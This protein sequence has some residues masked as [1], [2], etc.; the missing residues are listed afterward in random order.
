MRGMNKSSESIVVDVIRI[1]QVLRNIVS[2]AIK[3]TPMGGTVNVNYEVL[4]NDDP[5]LS[6][7]NKDYNYMKINVSD[8]GIGISAEEKEKLFGKFYRIKTEETENI[9]GTG[10]GLWITRKIS[11]EMNGK[12]SV[13]SIKDVG[14]HFIISF[15]LVD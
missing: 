1:K 6:K 11:E 5:C 10:L 3:F 4:P 14:S 12:I 8:T 13:E 2:N 7:L 15:P 9:G